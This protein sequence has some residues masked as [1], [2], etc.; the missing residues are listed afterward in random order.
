MSL[1]GEGRWQPGAAAAGALPVCQPGWGRLPPPLTCRLLPSSSCCCSCSERPLPRRAAA[2]RQ[3]PLG[4]P[5]WGGEAAISPGPSRTPGPRARLAPLT[6]FCRDWRASSCRSPALREDTGRSVRQAAAGGAGR[7]RAGAGRTY[8][9]AGSGRAPPRPRA[10][11]GPC[12]RGRASPSCWGPASAPW[13]PVAPR[14]SAARAAPLPAA[15]AHAPAA[16]PPIGRRRRSSALIGPA[17]ATSAAR[18]ARPR[19]AWGRGNG[20]SGASGAAEPG[21]IRRARVP[22]YG[23]GTAR[24]PGSCRRD[25]L[26]SRGQAAEKG[27]VQ[28]QGGRKLRKHKVRVKRVK[29]DLAQRRP[30]HGYGHRS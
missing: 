12:A 26:S 2:R 20:G 9:A 13:P 30:C 14:A 28:R 22:G 8:L 21:G 17:A 4:S 18:A 11:C 1:A 5:A 19:S 10:A 3:P 7:L 15:P 24:E 6:S 23:T 27:R 25:G 29:D 16:A